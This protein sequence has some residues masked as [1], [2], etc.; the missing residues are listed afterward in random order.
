VAIFISP[1]LRRFVYA[2]WL[3][4]AIGPYAILAQPPGGGRGSGR[5]LPVIAA[6][7]IADSQFGDRLEAL[8]TTRANES[9]TI[10]ANVTE[11][12][13]EIRFEDGD[14]V[15][16]GDILVMLEQE[17]ERAALKAAKAQLDER[18]SAFQRAQELVRQQAVSTATMDE[19]EAALR[20]AEGTVEGIEAR[21]RDRTIQ[22]PFDGILGL[23][24]ISI[25]AL[26]RPGD[27]IT[28]LDDL[29]RIKVE[30]DVPSLFLSMLEPGLAIRGRVAAYGEEI[31]EGQVTAVRTRIDPVTRTVTVRAEIPNDDGRLR[32]G[33]L[34]TIELQKNPR[35]A[36]LIPE[37]ALIQR[38]LES[39]VFAI[40]EREGVAVAVETPVRTG[41]R[42]PGRIEITSG[43]A[44]GDAVV[45]HGLM[46]V[47]SGQPVAVQ[48]AQTGD[49]PLVSFTGD[50]LRINGGR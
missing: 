19:R 10:T 25:G 12:V 36:L 15:S 29:S 31:F 48:M 45:V 3:S 49:E 27:V 5:P 41:A 34:M 24:E 28:T 46:H 44:A 20:Q 40:R 8:G 26:V 23:R 33:L 21:L 42:I 22:A 32:P 6:P 30:F 2:G 16:K 11:F 14:R 9:V 38:G 39:S 37:G 50:T 7:V 18:L 4:V 17:E 43:L 47:R 13:R 35:T 1:C